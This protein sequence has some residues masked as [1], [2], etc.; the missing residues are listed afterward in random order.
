MVLLSRARKDLVDAYWKQTVESRLIVIENVTTIPS[1]I[2]AKTVP[3]RKPLR[4][5]PTDQSFM[6]LIWDEMNLR[7]Y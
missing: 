5:L 6:M 4:V 2:M 7:V 3:F 1:V